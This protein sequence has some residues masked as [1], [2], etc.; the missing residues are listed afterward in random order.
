MNK[1]W[2]VAAGLIV[3]AT[4]SSA[5]A[6]DCPKEAERI[7][8]RLA[9][10][11]TSAP[12]FMPVIKTIGLPTAANAKAI[13]QRGFVLAVTKDGKV[14]AQGQGLAQAKDTE[15]FLD[16]M[17]KSALEAW[18]LDDRGPAKDAKFA[19]YIWADKDTPAKHVAAVATAAAK[20][21]DR[22][23]VR[24]LVAGKGGAVPPPKAATAI[25]AKVPTGEPEGTKYVVGELKKAVGGCATLVTALAISSIDKSTSKKYDL[26]DL[27]PKA[28]VD[29]GC[30]LANMDV[31]E[32][33]IVEW[34]GA[35]GSTFAWADLPKLGATDAQPLGKLVK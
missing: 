9:G 5:A 35:T 25:A 7:G 28:M 6:P 29:C 16:A 18:V 1:T 12:G 34:Y 23:L 13:D 8:K 27:V 24:L 3:W 32:W 10:L 4:G 26:V 22:F 14:F 21:S 20:V 31:F 2:L 17:W 15:Q 11:K 33:G 19:L 30:K